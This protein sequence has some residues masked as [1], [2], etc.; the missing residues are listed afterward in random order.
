VPPA[1]SPQAVAR[2]IIGDALA[3]ERASLVRKA[4]PRI[5]VALGEMPAGLG[6]LDDVERY[7]KK[8]ME[9]GPAPAAVTALSARYGQDEPAERPRGPR[10]EGPRGRSRGAGR[11]A[12]PVPG[13]HEPR[14]ME[15]GESVR[16]RGGAPRGARMAARD[17]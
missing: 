3:G 16:G 6:D 8:A 12:K 17:P 15:Q 10:R 7:F 2:G 9:R 1:D 13:V 14:E 5:R 4:A 11:P